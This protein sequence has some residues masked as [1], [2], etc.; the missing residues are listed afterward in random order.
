MTPHQVAQEQGTSG[1]RRWSC[2]CGWATPWTAYTKADHAAAAI[3]H[4]L[5]H[6][7]KEGAAP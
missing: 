4:E 6:R 5:D 2:T 1:Q 3:R 7:A